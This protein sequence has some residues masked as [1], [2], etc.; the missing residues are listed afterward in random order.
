MR[1]VELRVCVAMMD[2]QDVDAEMVRR[3]L[4]NTLLDDDDFEVVA[5]DV[6]AARTIGIADVDMD[7][8]DPTTDANLGAWHQT[9]LVSFGDLR[10]DRHVAEAMLG[11]AVTDNL[12][13]N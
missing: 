6:V 7:S 11:R 3:D 5:V 1:I 12:E 8:D 4:S 9:A 13:G 2:G 10:Q